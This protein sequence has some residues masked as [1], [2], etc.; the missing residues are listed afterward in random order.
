MKKFFA[1]LL[2]EPW[3]VEEAWLEVM[4]KTFVDGTTFDPKSLQ[5]IKS[6]RLFDTRS[7]QIRGSKAHIAIH[8][9]I[10]SKPNFL[11]EWLGIGV[12]LT[13]IVGDIQLVLDN[14]SVE[15][16]VLDIDSPGGAVTGI[17]EAASFIKEASK[18]KP[19]T[20]YIGGVGASAAYWLASGADEIVLD[21]T[22]R[23]GSIGIVIAYPNPQKDD[24][25]Y[26]EIVNTAS[27]NKRPD[28]GTE[29]GKKVI[30]EQLDALADVFI[31]TVATNRDVLAS[32][33]IN[34]FGK[35]G[36]LVGQQAVDVGMADRLGSF[37]ELMKEN[38]TEGDFSMKLTIDELKAD[39]KEIYDTVK[40]SG[41]TDITDLV[42]SH[43][44]AITAKDQEITDLE[45]KLE[46][47]E[48]NAD[49]LT[50]RVKSLEKR[51]AIRDEEGIKEKASSIMTGIL[52]ASNL[53]E[54]LHSKVE[55]QVD[56]NVHVTDGK[57]DIKGY[58]KAV[59]EEVKDW[60]EAIPA[61][62]PIQGVSTVKPSDEFDDGADDEIVDRMLAH[63]QTKKEA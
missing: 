25:Y 50:D 15:S 1:S 39:H 22:A 26:I 60:E 48:S 12:V 62:T 24:D 55:N 51:D 59:E 10:F 54:R 3:L 21:A 32:T 40:A 18:Q 11:T 44:E 57:L 4:L 19:I 17:N 23:V 9:P 30:I 20:A 35:G 52:V 13:D 47:S 14:D 7:A 31:D 6:D 49:D 43:E 63:V 46:D 58:T 56:Y 34:D 33:V 37:E 42:T 5:V 61:P 41:A 53:P 36:V 8:G 38:N 28:I 27:P 45:K 29:K 2:N 16:I